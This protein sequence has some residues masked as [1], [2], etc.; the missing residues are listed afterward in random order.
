M[1]EGYSVTGPVGRAVRY[2]GGRAAMIGERLTL[3]GRPATARQI[4]EAARDAGSGCIPY[5]GVQWPAV[6]LQVRHGHG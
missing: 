6:T 4:V 2:L 1:A 5:P 3:D